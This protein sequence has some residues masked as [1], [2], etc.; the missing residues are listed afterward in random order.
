MVL[1]LAI[2]VDII[3][4]FADDVLEFLILLDLVAAPILE[5]LLVLLDVAVVVDGDLEGVV[6]A[7]PV[8]DLSQPR[9]EDAVDAVVL[10]F[11]VVDLGLVVVELVLQV[12]VLGEFSFALGDLLFPLVDLI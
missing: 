2:A 11:E 12:F 10:D 7:L 6:P 5:G 9:L 8:L 3:L 4:E 1:A